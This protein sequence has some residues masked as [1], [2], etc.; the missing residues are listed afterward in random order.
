M[1][2][3]AALNDRKRMETGILAALIFWTLLLGALSLV[4]LTGPLPPEDTLNPLYVELAPVERP[5]PAPAPP[6]REEQVGGAER[7]RSDLAAS[8]AQAAQESPAPA[9]QNAAAPAAAP[10]PAAAAAPRPSAAQAAPVQE[11]QAAPVRLRADPSA[12]PAPRQPARTAQPFQGGA[13]PFAPLSERSLLAEA[14][15]APAPTPA[16]A[17]RSD[18]AAADRSAAS[19][20]P[21]VQDAFD[22]ALSSA[23]DRLSSAPPAGGTSAAGAAAGTGAAGSAGSGAAAA[24]AGGGTASG[25]G[26][27]AAGAFDFG[28]GI[29]RR[30]F[31]DPRIDIH[32][33]LLQGQPRDLETTVTFRIAPGGTVYPTSIRFNPPLPLDLSDFLRNAFSRWQFSPSSSDG[34]VAFRYSIRVR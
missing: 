9:R 11:E 30:L 21:P 25:T 23:A 13:D 3:A 32:P 19:G 10:A 7:S 2:G 27:A 33:S 1:T 6:P 34:Q 29:A 8:S 22:R 16:P 14:P 31:S 18:L 5:V 17:A 4:K 24:G 12:A 28:D 15:P 26:G 20:G